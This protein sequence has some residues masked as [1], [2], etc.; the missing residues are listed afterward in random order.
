MLEIALLVAASLS[1]AP[2]DWVTAEDCREAYFANRFAEAA[3]VCG[4]HA[5]KGHAHSQHAMGF[6]L[7]EPRSGQPIDIDAAVSWYELAAAQGLAKSAD[8]LAKIYRREGLID[9]ARALKWAHRAADLG[10]AESMAIIGEAYEFGQGEAIDGKQALGWYEKAFAAGYAEGAVAIARL[11]E[12]GLG[13]ERSPENQRVWLRRAMERGSLDGQMSLAISLLQTN[14]P[15]A[16]EE[17]VRL[18]QDAANKGR[19]DGMRTLAAAL[20]QG[21]GVPSDPNRGIDLLAEAAKGGDGEANFMLGRI[22][23]GNSVRVGR[24]NRGLASQYLKESAKLEDPIGFVSRGLIAE[25]GLDAPVDLKKAA[26]WYEK[27]IA[28]YAYSAT[29]IIYLTNILTSPANDHP[30]PTRAAE[31]LRRIADTEGTASFNLAMMHF[32]GEAPNASTAEGLRWLT[33]AANLGSSTAHVWLGTRYWGGIPPVEQSD[34]K[35]FEHFTVA[36]NAGDEDAIYQL[37]RAHFYGRGTIIDRE[38]GVALFR[39]AADLGQAEAIVRI[40]QINSARLDAKGASRQLA[41]TVVEA[42]GGDRA[43]Q[44]EAAFD[45][46]FGPAHLRD[47]TKGAYWFRRAAEQRSALAAY[48]LGGMQAAGIGGVKDEANALQLL[49]LAANSFRESAARSGEPCTHNG[50]SMCWLAMR[51]LAQAYHS[52]LAGS[53]PARFD[54]IRDSVPEELQLE[55]IDAEEEAAAAPRVAVTPSAALYRDELLQCDCI[56]MSQ[57]SLAPDSQPSGAKAL[58]LTVLMDTLDEDDGTAMREQI[59][60]ASTLL[61]PCGIQIR[62]VELVLLKANKPAEELADEVAANP[63]LGSSRVRVVAGTGF[64]PHIGGWSMNSEGL[65]ALNWD[66]VPS[67]HPAGLTLA[68]EFGHMLGH[69][70][71]PA[72]LTPNIMQYDSLEMSTFTPQQCERMRSSPFLQ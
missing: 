64:S 1:G 4:P 18:A 19:F 15:E 39:K 65:I 55:G 40:S 3:R 22:Y 14:S 63:R 44:L 67:E 16:H 35:A 42:E 27:A 45:Y 30:N 59:T 71:H 54:E 2:L 36:A 58:D 68:H 29:A 57:F 49:Q 46:T 56:R 10:F 43:K 17:G 26:D 21:M 47:Q 41:A 66:V 6:I 32:R 34:S 25:H 51:R 61:A 62:D 52:R 69:M 72:D 53:D 28:Q 23:L 33:Q 24:P 12:K 20:L 50:A 5:Q 60:N 38:R 13:M 11:Y 7:S 8:N 31:L 48:Y 37:G 9:Y 70:S